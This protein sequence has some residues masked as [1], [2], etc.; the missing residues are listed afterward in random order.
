LILESDCKRDFATVKIKLKNVVVLTNK[1]QKAWVH[2]GG[3][4]ILKMSSKNNE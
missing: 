1:K 4:L 3:L 2:K